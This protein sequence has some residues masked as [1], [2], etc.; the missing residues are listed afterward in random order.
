MR[1][2]PDK[3]R[4]IW[5]READLEKRGM[6]DERGSPEEKRDQA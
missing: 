5:K 1:G 6:P 3:E 4:Q 2:R